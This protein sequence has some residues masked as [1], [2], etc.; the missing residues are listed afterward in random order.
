MAKIE[1]GATNDKSQK[2]CFADIPYFVEADKTPGNVIKP[3]QEK[4]AEL[5]GHEDG[6]KLGELVPVRLRKTEI[7]PEVESQ[8]K[9][10]GENDNIAAKEKKFPFLRRGNQKFH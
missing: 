10:Q 9:G 4:G 6:Q 1:N 3:E 8:V 5:H 7:K 2:G